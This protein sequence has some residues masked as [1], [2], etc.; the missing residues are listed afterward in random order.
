MRS[1]WGASESDNV[2]F[3]DLNAGYK[4]VFYT[5]LYCEYSSSC[6]IVFYT[7]YIVNIHQVVYF[8]VCIYLNKKFK[9]TFKYKEYGQFIFFE[10]ILREKL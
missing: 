1:M 2:L 8:S 4:I 6:K 7:I 3:L 5:I 10:K 9:V